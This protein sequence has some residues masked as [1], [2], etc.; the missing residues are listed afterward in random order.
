MG[1]SA[2]EWRPSDAQIAKLEAKIKPEQ[3]APLKGGRLHPL[4][5]YERFYAGMT[6]KGDNVIFGE[7]LLADS[8][9]QQPGIRIVASKR[10]FPVI[11]D[12]GC[13]VI[14]LTYSMKTGAIV[15]F[16]CNGFA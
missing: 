4:S 15:S 9:R 1:A 13:A 2:Q 10:N 7:L 14:H 3:L 5:E 8:P 6:L 12:G 16:E 11:F